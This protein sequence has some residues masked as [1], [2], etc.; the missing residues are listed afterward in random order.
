MANGGARRKVPSTSMKSG[1]CDVPKKESWLPWPKGNKK[2]RSDVPKKET[3]LEAAKNSITSGANRF[4][5]AFSSEPAPP[6]RGLKRSYTSIREKRKDAK[7]LKKDAEEL[8]NSF[9]DIS[10]TSDLA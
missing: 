5:A 7:K 1:H 9:K 8:Q 2:Q 4:K 10:I 3:L 6:E